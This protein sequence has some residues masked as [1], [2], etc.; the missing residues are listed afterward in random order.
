MKNKYMN[1]FFTSLNF[2]E[3]VNF[4][5]EYLE[6]IPGI[7]I[8]NNI[9]IKKQLLSKQNRSL[10]GALES[11]FFENSKAFLFFNFENTEEIFKDERN[12]ESLERI[13]LWIDDIFKN[14]WLIKD[15]NVITDTSF[16]IHN[17]VNTNSEAASLRLQYQLT[18]SNGL[19]ETTK[20]T[21][22]EIIEFSK[23]HN[24]IENYFHSKNSSSQGFM[25]EKNFS[26]VNRGLI[27]VK[28]AREARNLAYKI[29]NYCSALETIFSTDN[30]ELSHKLSERIAF[31]LKED[32]AVLETFKLIKK[33]YGVRSK[34]T[35]GD[36][37]D[38]KQ[39][40]TL[41]YLS[42]ELDN[43][44]RFSINKII[45]SDKLIKIFESPKNTIDEYFENLIFR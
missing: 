43:K 22:D 34:L 33:S 1:Q 36:S 39:I 42:I 4:D 44:L 3:L 7:N 8:S 21:K 27:F 35:H 11:Y 41:D 23:Y 15:N 29:S 26:R 14:L 12:L 28:Q 38:N 45:K 2:I 5:V 24:D 10:I 25:L 31:F 19:I 20:F 37:L 32:F 16:L 18:K 13:L 40:D 17:D 6:I 30:V 9:E